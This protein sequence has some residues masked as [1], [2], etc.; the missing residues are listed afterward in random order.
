M[1]RRLCGLG[2]LILLLLAATAAAAADGEA[3]DITQ[4]CNFSSSYTRYKPS[5]MTDRKY[6]TKWSCTNT[7]EPYIQIA[8]PA[9]VDCY[10][11]Y[12]CFADQPAKW[13]LQTNE[14]GEWITMAEMTDE[15]AH[16]YVPLY[17]ARSVRII[18]VNT[19]KYQKIAVNEIYL[20]SQGKVPGWVQRWQPT[21]GDADLMFLVAHPDDEL[22]F[23]GGAIPT[24]AVEQQRK[25]VVAYMT[26]SN[27]TRRSELLNGLWAMGVRNYPIIGE[28]WDGYST[29]AAKTAKDWGRSNAL[30][31]IV[32][33]IRRTK[34]KVLVTHD[35]GGE[36]GHGAHRL[37][38]ELA[39]QA[40][41]YAANAEKYAESAETYGTWQVLKLYSHLYGENQITFDWTVPLKNMDGKTGIELAAGAYALHVTQEST[42][43][44]M[45]ETGTK[46]DNTLFGL[47][48]SE[49]GED[50]LKNDFLEN[51]L[52]PVTY[53]P[54]PELPEPVAAPSPVV[55][56]QD[57]LP[58][59]NGKGFY[60]GGEF[61]YDSDEIGLW[62]YVSPTLKVI[63]QRKI[64]VDAPLRWFEAEIWTNVEAGELLNSIQYNPE[65]PG[66]TYVDAS[67]TAK[68]YGVVFGMNADYYT[69]RVR[70]IWKQGIVIRDGVILID[71]PYNE[72][73][74][75]FP[76]L[77]TLAL[78]PDGRMEVYPSYELTAQDYLDMGATD[79]YSFGP[80]LINRGELNPNAE[81]WG[82]S[83]NPRCAIGMVEPGHYVVVVAEGRMKTSAGISM[84]HLAS[85][86]WNKHCEVAFNMDGGQTAVMLFMGKQLNA[87][88]LYDGKTSAR[89]TTEILGAG[90]SELVSA[91]DDSK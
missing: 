74:T 91:K 13:L 81:N 78:F 88:G 55:G 89:E 6:T 40:Y 10:G 52:E 50:V 25:V 90:Y 2:C 16:A 43:F 72:A 38:A 42:K 69:Y 86:M 20:F 4:D 46:Y 67:E 35:F 57:I 51:V 79:V 64:D 41:E 59:L 62:V 71:D 84:T 1:T 18:A 15:Y 58:E 28:F 75:K 65:R 56:C 63:I 36:Y 73:T 61:V 44:S 83:L 47:V 32:E 26:Y 39:A 29:T 22:L 34:P 24:C 17:G 68:K 53:V 80:Y 77:D 11:V 76:N 85:L 82:K 14:T 70:S 9:G 8:M 5:L 45:E 48:Y 54:A 3:L 60:D 66:K 7:Y 37:T 27:T 12:I 33:C 23:F 19:G 30:S 31:F 21:C 87:I 49:V